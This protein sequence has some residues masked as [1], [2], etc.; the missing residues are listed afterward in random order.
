MG[1]DK[2]S[3]AAV[4]SVPVCATGATGG[5]I[6]ALTAGQSSGGFATIHRINVARGKGRVVRREINK[7]RSDF[8]RLG[9]AAK[10]NFLVH[11]LEHL[12]RVFGT[13]HWSENVARSYGTYADFGS[14]FEC[15]GTSQLDHSRFGGIVIGIKRV[16]HNAVGRGG[17]QDHSGTLSCG[18]LH[19]VAGSGLRHVEDSSQI[20]PDDLLPLFGSDVEEFVADADAGVVDEHIDA[21]HDANR[22]GHRGFDLHEVGDVGD[23]GFGDERKLMTNGCTGFGIVIE[24]ADARAFLEKARGGGSANAAGASGDED[25]FVG[26]AAH[27]MNC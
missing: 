16:A 8:F 14:E 27:W 21:V 17:L 25:A 24:D 26:Q 9:M 13:L 12:V 6:H 22:V 19:H 7:Q 2:T 1:C 15:H 11:F 10:G 4:S 23:D 18:S 3:Q 5:A 20:D